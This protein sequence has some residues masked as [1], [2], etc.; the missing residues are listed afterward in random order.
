MAILSPRAGADDSLQ[1]RTHAT[2]TDFR[3]GDVGV[4]RRNLGHYVENTGNDVLQLVGV[5]RA[6]RY[7][8]VSL[9]DWLGHVPPGLVMQHFNLT[10]EDLEKFPKEGRGMFPA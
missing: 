6:P 3:A 2:T 9:A 1:Y 10:R 7:E 4:V 5:F 8:E